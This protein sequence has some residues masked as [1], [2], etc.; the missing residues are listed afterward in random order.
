MVGLL[1]R[2]TD[3]SIWRSLVQCPLYHEHSVNFEVIIILCLFLFWLSHGACG[4]LVPWPGIKPIHP[5]LGVWSQPLD[6]HES[7]SLSTITITPPF[8]SP[9]IGYCFQIANHFSSTHSY[10]EHKQ[11][12]LIFPDSLLAELGGSLVSPDGGGL[13]LSQ[14]MGWLGWMGAGRVFQVRRTMWARTQW[15]EGHR[16]R[17]SGR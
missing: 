15:W 5:A 2:F 7:P 3:C 16:T 1:W 8:H 10:L 17:D 6:H 14:R 13:K 9:A 12:Q 4:I 11:A